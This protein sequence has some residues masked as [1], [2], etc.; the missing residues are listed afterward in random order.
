MII[1]G[2]S[3]QDETPSIVSN[4]QL[5]CWTKYS[6]GK[7]VGGEYR[8]GAVKPPEANCDWLPAA[9]SSHTI[10]IACVKTFRTPE[11]AVEWLQAAA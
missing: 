2:I 1:A 10:L 9:V 8:Y 3:L 7:P 5:Y 4:A 6:V 11:D